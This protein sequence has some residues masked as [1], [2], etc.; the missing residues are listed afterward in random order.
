MFH[1]F[2]TYPPAE[3]QGQMINFMKNLAIMGGLA[4]VVTYGPG[5]LSLDA[6]TRRE[7]KKETKKRAS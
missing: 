6:W 2:W 1:N 5:L 7:Q 3:Q 4:M